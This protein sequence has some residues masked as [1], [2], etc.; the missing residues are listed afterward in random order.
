MTDK[1]LLAVDP[2]LMDSIDRRRGDLSR[3]EFIEH[4]IKGH[5]RGAATRESPGE[6]PYV[7]REEFRRYQR[8]TKALLKEF[9]DHLTALDVNRRS[10]A[11]P[12]E[13]RRHLRD[14]P[15]PE[16]VPAPYRRAGEGR[17]A[18]EAEY[19]APQA[20]RAARGG[21]YREGCGVQE[22]TQR[23]SSHRSHPAGDSRPAPR[24]Q[25]VRSESIYREDVRRIPPVRNQQGCGA[26]GVAI[27]TNQSRDVRRTRERLYSDDVDEIS[28]ELSRQN[29][30]PALWLPAVL[31]FGFG[32]TLTS[33]MVFAKGGMEANPLLTALLSMLGGNIIAF[34]VIKTL[35]LGVLAFISF[36]YMRNYGW[37]IP[38]IL[39]VVGGYLVVSNIGVLLQMQ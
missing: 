11:P 36:K 32:D 28:K 34:V 9:L 7:S 20:R 16:E 15:F 26:G 19:R 10:E 14:M 31:L 1:K 3:A 8:D 33:T 38:A 22:N 4:C 21:I 12:P 24:Q 25:R 17:P 29:M 6:E 27:R 13:P 2:K 37:V 5:L 35:I 18:D 39:T 23:A 30:Y